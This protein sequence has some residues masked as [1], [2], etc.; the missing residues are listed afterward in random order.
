MPA[1][2]RP[3]AAVLA[4]TT[5]KESATSR[6]RSRNST[7]E[8]DEVTRLGEGGFGVVLKARHRA[9]GKTVAIKYLTSPDDNTEEEPDEAELRHEARL[10]E[11]C[12]GNPHLVGFEGLAR[13]TATGNLRLVMEYVAAPS[14][15]AFMRKDSRHGRPLPE[16]KVRAIMRKL[17]TGAK[18]MHARH[19]VH[20]DIKPANILVGQDGHLVKICDLGIGISMSDPPPYTQVGTMPYKAPEILL[21]KPDYDALVDCWSLGCVMAEMLAG[22]TLFEDDGRED[23]MDDADHVAQLWGIFGVLGMPDDRTWPE[24]KSLPL[25]GKVMEFKSSLPPTHKMLPEGQ[26]HSRLRDIFPGEKLSEQGF[27]VLLGLLTYNPD[28]R[29]TAA[30]ALKLPW[31]A[32]PPPSAKAV[33]VEALPLPRNKVSR[34]MAPL[35]VLKS[36]VALFIKRG[37]RLFRGMSQV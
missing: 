31:F 36:Q 5:T 37:E 35:T 27:Q 18:L 29:L 19:V 2:K 13:D 30:K 14:L 23:H 8:Y 20:R 9:T 16:P 12:N 11:A 34:F 22:K 26:E 28:K 1:R 15:H 25:T 10:L 3:A 4:T 6:K 24:F 21:R 32:A 7:D 33:K 17:L